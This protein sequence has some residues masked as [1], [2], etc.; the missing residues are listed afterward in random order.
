MRAFS[1]SSSEQINRD[2]TNALLGFLTDQDSSDSCSPDKFHKLG[3]NARNAV[4][5]LK[6]YEKSEVLSPETEDLDNSLI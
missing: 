5:G 1:D 3:Q 4:K 6:T 2:D